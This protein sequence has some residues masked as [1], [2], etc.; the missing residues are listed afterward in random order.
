VKKPLL[1]S[2]SNDQAQVPTK[3]KWGGKNK[4]RKPKKKKVPPRNETSR[5]KKEEEGIPSSLVLPKK[6]NRGARLHGDLGESGGRRTGRTKR[7]KQ[8]RLKQSSDTQRKEPGK[9]KSARELQKIRE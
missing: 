5:A 2:P 4:Q 9:K 6:K 3:S 8:K 7:E 1:V